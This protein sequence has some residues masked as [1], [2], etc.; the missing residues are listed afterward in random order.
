MRI[1]FDQGTP[2][3]LRPYLKDHIVRTAAQ[4]GWAT[5]QNGDLLNAAEGTGFDMLLTTDKNMC[6][7]QNLSGRNISVIILG[8]QQ[9]PDIRPHVQR[10]VEAVNSATPGSYTEVVIPYRAAPKSEQGRVSEKARQSQQRGRDDYRE[11]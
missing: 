2:V 6:H 3:P 1:L 10:V 5:L 4:E 11:Q 8:K 9:W 7:H